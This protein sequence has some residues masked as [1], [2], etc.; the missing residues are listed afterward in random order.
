MDTPSAYYQPPPSRWPIVGSL[1]LLALASGFVLF[2]AKSNAGP[3]LMA[4]GGLLLIAMLAGWFGAVIRESLAGKLEGQ[5][6]GSFRWGMVWFIFSEVMFF[7]GFFGALFY[8]R[9]ISVPELADAQLL[10]PGYA[11]GWPTAGPGIKEAFTPM[12]GSGIPA[13]NTLILLSSG[14]TVTWAHWGLQS[15]RRWQIILGLALTILLG[16]TFLGLQAHEYMEAAFSIRTGIYG[17]TFFMLTGFHGLHVTLGAIML[18]VI[19]GR[20]LAGHFSADS[21][22]GFEAAAWYWHF[23]DVVWLM[24]FVFVYWL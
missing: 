2:L 3:Y 6:D 22:F 10:W 23:V 9:V 24:L 15:G 20:V 5:V 16:A 11:G 7:A 4:A 14:V 18:S 19:L 1:A 13:V 17:A 8:A 21:H 12:P